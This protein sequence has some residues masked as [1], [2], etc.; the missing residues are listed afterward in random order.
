MALGIIGIFLPV[1]PTT[2]FLLLTAA[3]YFKGSPR[4]YQWLLNHKYF[5]PHIRNFRENKSIPLRAKIISLSLMWGTMLYCIFY[6]IP[7]LWVQIVLALIAI[8]VTYHILSFKTL[9]K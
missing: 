1:L 3:L 2:P 7:Y 6:L 9:K 4:L 8:G 5:G